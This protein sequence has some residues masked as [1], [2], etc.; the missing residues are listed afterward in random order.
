MDAL[1]CFTKMAARQNILYDEFFL[2]AAVLEF[3]AFNCDGKGG[4]LC[5]GDGT[6]RVI[7]HD[8]VNKILF[9]V[10]KERLNSFIRGIYDPDTPTDDL[11]RIAGRLSFRLGELNE[12]SKYSVGNLAK[13]IHK[14]LQDET[15]ETFRYFVEQK[16]DVDPESL[17]RT[18]L[19]H[20]NTGSRLFH[21]PDCKFYEGKECTALFVNREEALAAGFKPCKLCE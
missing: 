2:E 18:G 16:A 8:T 1:L 15:E 7:D 17:P 13:Q 21:R 9:G 19:L 20:G 12:L 3:I 10:P 5:R 4:A 11:V 6:L 14:E